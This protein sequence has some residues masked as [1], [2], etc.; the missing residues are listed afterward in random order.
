M[1]SKFSAAFPHRDQLQA[2]TAQA[3]VTRNALLGGCLIG[4]KG[5]LCPRP[6][7]GDV[8]KSV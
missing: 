8:V 1:E 6:P 2:V 5:G 4:N 7:A 3:R